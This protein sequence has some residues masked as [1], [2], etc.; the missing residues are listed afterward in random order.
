MV[1]NRSS[2]I[3][4]TYYGNFVISHTLGIGKTTL[5]KAIASMEIEGFPKHHRVLRK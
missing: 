5:L 2:N 4:K 1:N 3:I